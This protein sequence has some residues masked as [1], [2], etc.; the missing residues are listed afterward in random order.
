M[1]VSDLVRD[2]V[3]PLRMQQF[4]H[5]EKG[6]GNLRLAFAAAICLALCTVCVT[7]VKANP[8]PWSHAGG[9][10]HYKPHLPVPEPVTIVLVG[11]GLFALWFR[12]KPP[13][14][15]R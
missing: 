1:V 10:G 11:C 5:A 9:N 12:Q 8:P 3:S 2:Q 15:R 14:G 7:P 6:A 4:P 13:T